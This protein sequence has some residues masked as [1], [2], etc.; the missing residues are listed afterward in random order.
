MRVR[1][2]LTA[3]KGRDRLQP[4]NITSLVKYD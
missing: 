3:L 4:L 1:V 2:E